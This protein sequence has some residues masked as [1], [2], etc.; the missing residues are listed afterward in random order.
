MHQLLNFHQENDYQNF[1][2]KDKDKWGSKFR[3]PTIIGS[4][5]SMLWV[6][7]LCYKMCYKP[8]NLQNIEFEKLSVK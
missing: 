5:K 4:C 3:N 1:K 7:Y 6:I 2:A 8:I